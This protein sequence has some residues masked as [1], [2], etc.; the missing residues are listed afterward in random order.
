MRAAWL[1]ASWTALLL[2]CGGAICETEHLPSPWASTPVPGACVMLPDGAAHSARDPSC[3]VGTEVDDEQDGGGNGTLFTAVQLDQHPCTGEAVLPGRLAAANDVDLYA[4]RNCKLPFLVPN[5]PTARATQVP[6]LAVDKADDGTEVCLFAYCSLG[7][8]T[9]E[10]CPSVGSW[11]GR[12]AEG[13]L[14]CC[15]RNAGPLVTKTSCD[16]FGPEVSGFISVRSVVSDT[17]SNDA[18]ILCHEP[19]TLRFSIASPP[20]L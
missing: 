13:M 15:R 4:F 16:S 8:T 20:P 17:A 10:A 14:G 5:D 11:E 18:G 3:P 1:T 7:P 2:V 19:Y 9:R 12:L 6:T